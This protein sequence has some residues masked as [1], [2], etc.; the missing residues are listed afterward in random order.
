MSN[1]LTQVKMVYKPIE[2]TVDVIQ[3]Q[4]PSPI[5]SDPSK[6]GKNYEKR[7]SKA[8]VGAKNGMVRILTF[9][10]EALDDAITCT[11]K[12]QMFKAA[13]TKEFSDILARAVASTPASFYLP[14]IDSIAIVA[15]TLDH[16][17]ELFWD[18]YHLAM[19]V[20][21]AS[22]ALFTCLIPG[23]RELRDVLSDLPSLEEVVK[24]CFELKTVGKFALDDAWDYRRWVCSTISKATSD[25][26]ESAFATNV[27][28]EFATSVERAGLSLRKWSYRLTSVNIHAKF[29][30][31][32][33]ADFI[34]TIY[35]VKHMIIDPSYTAPYD[36]SYRPSY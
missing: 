7:I 22:Y 28:V 23:D 26:D 16:I 34:G 8:V 12:F 14:L 11:L 33:M 20:K 2:L 30:A 29:S 25:T 31:H 15:G 6:C 3:N 36:Y 32:A 4:F 27:S 35:E 18:A 17:S 13:L 5:Q 9:I 21:E 24:T 19:S 1:I 10:N